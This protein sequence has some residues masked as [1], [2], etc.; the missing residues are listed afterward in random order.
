MAFFLTPYLTEYDQTLSADSYIDPIGT[1]IIWS[2]FGRQVFKNRVNSV[3][4]DVRNYTL[5]LFHHF[6]V[7]KLVADDAVQLGSSLQQKYGSKEALAFKHACLILLE[8]LFVYSVLRHERLQGAEVQTAG[9]LGISKARRRW[10]QA[11]GDPTLVFTHES[12]GQILVRQL[13]LGVSGRYKTPLIEMGFFDSD[14]QYHRLRFQPRWLEAETFISGERDGVLAKVERQAYAFLKASIPTLRH[15]GELRFRTDVPDKLTKAYALAFSSP[16]AVG[17]YARQFWLRQTGLDSGA[18]GALL[19]VLE[20]EGEE[21]Q[22]AH[23][24]VAQALEQDLPPPERA[25]LEQIAKIEPFLSDCA[26]LFSLM[27]SKRDHTIGDVAARWK[28]FG[29]GSNALP[30]LAEQVANAAKLP[31]LKREASDRFARLQRM[32]KAGDLEAQVRELATYHGHVMRGRGQPAWLTID[33]GGKIKVH[34]RTTRRIDPG[35]WRPGTWQNDYYVPQFRH[36]V[37]GLQG[38]EA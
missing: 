8:N 28:A 26:L 36:L 21:P 5:N 6:L 23:Q 24:V 2:A 10:D 34:A 22:S 1:L 19:T 35:E 15:K 13:G 30:R 17:A 14:Y 12:P 3:S 25:K 29:R 9:V 16:T 20:A 27:T 18:A 7:R 37:R 4:N 11:S 32:A 33:A 38:A 31:A